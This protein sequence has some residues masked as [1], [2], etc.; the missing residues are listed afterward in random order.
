MSRRRK[1]AIGLAMLISYLLQLSLFPELKISG[2]Q[3]D[4]MLVIAAVVAIQDGPVEGCIVGFI[5][6]LA[7]DLTGSQ[8]V[9]VGA[10]SRAATA[11][12]LG[13]FKDMFVT[14]TVL[15][16][17]VLV[18]FGG[19]VEQLL[20]H[21]GLTV[22]GSEVLAPLNVKHLFTVAFY[23]SIVIL[24]FFPIIKKFKGSDSADQLGAVRTGM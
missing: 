16:P 13:V 5:G 9:G 24:V 2:V 12:I 23:D 3:P 15:L 1:I 7:F 22:L 10:F 20:Y 19:L 14:Y 6:G 17:F 4:L 18:F 11:F 21:G 8:V